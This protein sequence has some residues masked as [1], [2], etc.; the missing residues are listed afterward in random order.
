MF[1]NCYKYWNVFNAFQLI[2]LTFLMINAFL[3]VSKFI[4]YLKLRLNLILMD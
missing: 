3:L 2:K 1:L 4:L